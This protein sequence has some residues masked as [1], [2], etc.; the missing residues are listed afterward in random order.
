MPWAGCHPA[1]ARGSAVQCSGRARACHPP[2]LNLGTH[3][4]HGRLQDDPSVRT[5]SKMIRQSVVQA[6][7]QSHGSCH[8]PMAASHSTDKHTN[9]LHPFRPTSLAC[10]PQPQHV[11]GAV[12]VASVPP[13]K[14]RSGAPGRTTGRMCA[15]GSCP[16]PTPCRASCV[17]RALM[18]QPGP[19]PG[20]H[21]GQGQ[22]HVAP[23]V[24]RRHAVR[25]GGRPLA[26]APACC[27]CGCRL[28]EL[29]VVL[30]R[31]GTRRA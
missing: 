29:A 1:S 18:S 20:S 7:L 22:V 13:V 9:V 8:P 30:T 11:L 3:L 25:V 15:H 5:G 31:P 12:V 4:R 21:A 27:C 10:A 2:A 26:A 14:C 6:A 16:A 28:P 17:G 24:A 23:A 19:R